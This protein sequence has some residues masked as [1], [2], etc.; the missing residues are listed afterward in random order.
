M[1]FPT[2]AGMQTRFSQAGFCFQVSGV[3]ASRKWSR[4]A[5]SAAR[6]PAGDQLLRSGLGDR[7]ALFSTLD[8]LARWL[9]DRWAGEE[10]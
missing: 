5:N 9:G 4:A 6:K 3:S 1:T 10:G 8:R 7:L 2:S